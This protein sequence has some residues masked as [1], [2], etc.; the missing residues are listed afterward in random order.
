MFNIHEQ[1]SQWAKSY[2]TMFNCH[3]EI[4]HRKVRKKTSKDRCNKRT[5]KT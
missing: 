5:Y 4:M 2:K 1:V 3:Q